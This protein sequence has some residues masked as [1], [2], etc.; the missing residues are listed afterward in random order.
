MATSTTPRI[1][2]G[3]LTAWLERLCDR[4]APEAPAPK[5]APTPVPTALQRRLDESTEAVT[6]AEQVVVLVHAKLVLLEVACLALQP[7]AA[8]A[9]LADLLAMAA[10]AAGVPLEQREWLVPLAMLLR[11]QPRVARDVLVTLE[12]WRQ[13][14]ERLAVARAWRAG[15]LGASPAALLREVELLDA[16]GLRAAVFPLCCLGETFRGVPLLATLFP[17]QATEAI[18]RMAAVRAVS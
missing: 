8:G 14:R 10:D 7:A 5:P 17:R 3:P 11:R 1:S 18:A 2:T 13:A 15:L 9:R 12:R 6:A 16:R 4:L